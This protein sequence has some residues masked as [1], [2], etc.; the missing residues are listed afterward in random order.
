MAK[1][2]KR[3]KRGGRRARKGKTNVADRAGCSVKVDIAPQTQ[4][5]FSAN[6]VYSLTQIQLSEFDRAMAVA[7][8]YQHYRIKSAK[9]T[10]R[11]AYDTYQ[12]D[13][14]NNMSRPD[15]YY[16]IDKA[17][18]LSP[19]TATI[20]Q[21]KEMGSRPRKADEKPVVITW[22]PSVLAEMESV[23]GATASSYQTSPWLNT[24]SSQTA[25]RGI[26]WSVQQL[27]GTALNYT[28]ELEVQIEFKKPV[29]TALSVDDSPA[30]PAV[31][32][33]VKPLEHYIAG[34]LTA[35]LSS[36]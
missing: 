4:P 13:G 20:T 34:G 32:K 25:H 24:S 8:A 29:W 26:F 9:L 30:I 5:H 22:S 27:F 10:V 11:V 18:V 2:H 12:Y 23:A 6:A 14:V 33:V 28:A 1:G 3:S 35:P 36:L 15:L 31:V 7:K 16:Q 21:L 19:A 17:G